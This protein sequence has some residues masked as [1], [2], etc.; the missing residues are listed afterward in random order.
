MICPLKSG[1]IQTHGI[2]ESAG[3]QEIGNS[4]ALWEWQQFLSDCGTSV[5]VLTG[6]LLVVVSGSTSAFPMLLL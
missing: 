1:F 2:R 4:F 6:L 5:G 3:C